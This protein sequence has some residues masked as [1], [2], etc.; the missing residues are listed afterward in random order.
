M[1]D[2]EVEPGELE[3]IAVGKEG[4]QGLRG[5]GEL[6]ALVRTPVSTD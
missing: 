6:W 1:N 3:S 4:S 5:S 2:E